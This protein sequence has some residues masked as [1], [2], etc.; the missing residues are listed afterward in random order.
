MDMVGGKA[1]PKQLRI[2]IIT[3]IGHEGLCIFIITLP[4][5]LNIMSTLINKGFSMI[6]LILPD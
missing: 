4:E 3:M 2:K 6:K 1:E 5:G